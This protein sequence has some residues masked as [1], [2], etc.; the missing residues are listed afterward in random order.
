[1]AAD[2]PGS[3]LKPWPNVVQHTQHSVCAWTR[4]PQRARGTFASRLQDLKFFCSL[5]SG[6]T[7]D[8]MDPLEL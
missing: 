6:K 4:A 7:G 8:Y 5:F 2:Q 3:A 1:M